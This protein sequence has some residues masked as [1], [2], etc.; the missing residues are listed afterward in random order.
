VQVPG[1][2]DL[3]L[4]LLSNWGMGVKRFTDLKAWQLS[5]SLKRRVDAVIARR[6]ASRDF[7]FCNQASEAA[8]SAPPNIAEGFG[9]FHHRQFAHFVS[10]ARASLMETQTNLVEARD[11]RYVTEAEFQEL[12][13]LS[14]ETIAVTTGL[15]RYLQE[16]RDQS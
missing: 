3:A 6:Q 16:G 9:R 4:A 5:M 13:K 8:G 10:I 7:K 14:D 2:G 1:A 12:W 11:K 15:L